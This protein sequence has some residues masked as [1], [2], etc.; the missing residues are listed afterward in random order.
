M[1]KGIM[2]L[3]AVLLAWGVAAGYLW[4]QWDRWLTEQN[5]RH[6]AW[7]GVRMTRDGLAIASV[8]LIRETSGGQ[9]RVQAQNLAVTLP[10]LAHGRL[11]FQ[12]LSAERLS[13]DWPSAEPSTDEEPMDWRA[14]GRI[15]DWL[16]ET[17][18]IDSFALTLPCPKGSCVLNGS[19]TLDQA[20]RDRFPLALL[21]ILQEQDLRAVINGVL[22][23]TA[24]GWQVQAHTELDG[25]R[26]LQLEARLHDAT[27][28]LSGSLQIPRLPDTAALFTWMNQW[29][30][31]TGP[32]PRTPTG[33]QINLTWQVEL[34]TA[35][36]ELFVERVRNGSG[37]LDVEGDFP[38]PWPV[39]GLGHVQGAL[40]MTWLGH[41]GQWRPTRLR[42]ALRL[43]ELA[44]LWPDDLPSEWAPAAVN[45][46]S[47]PVEGD[48]EA[49]LGIQLNLTMEGAISG[50]IHGRL[51]LLSMMPWHIGI[52]QGQI[53]IIGQRLSYQDW[54][55]Q[56][57]RLHAPF[58]AQMEAG[59]LGLTLESGASLEVEEL[60]NGD[61]HLPLQI[62]L[63]DAKLT[64]QATDEAFDVAFSSPIE[65]SS[66]AVRQALLKTQ[67]WS[68]KGAL[69]ASSQGLS[70]KGE[71]EN[72][73]ALKASVNARYPVSDGIQIDAK[74]QDVF[75]RQGNPLADTFAD[76]P[77]VLTFSNG[78]LQAGAELVMPLNEKPLSLIVDAQLKDVDGI[79][80]RMEL[81]KLNGPVKAQ[82]RNERL[83]VAF[84]ELTLHQANPGV[85]LGPIR[86]HGRY[87]AA[88][89]HL[90]QG[91]LDWETVEIG[92]FAGQ[93]RIAAGQ[94][95]F[96]A[97]RQRI[98]IDVSGLEIESILQAYPAEGLAGKG[99][100][101]GRLPLI[102]DRKGL[103]VENG[104]VKARDSGYLRFQ[105]EKIQAMG[106][107]N[108]AMQLVAE[109]LEDFHY[110]HLSSRV[111]YAADGTLTLAIVLQGRNPDVEKG[112]QI[113]L[114]V[115][116]QENLPNLF[117]SLQLSDRVNEQ[118]RERVEKKLREPQSK[119]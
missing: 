81:H 73:G 40:D 116:L 96:A 74:F 119:P 17:I 88:K 84:P 106:R 109:A 34:A 56:K 68:F 102:I 26:L 118:V 20:G 45:V 22:H 82:W 77:A 54:R 9:Q 112:R 64:T 43:T 69:D 14:I 76:W 12:R 71:V 105:S 51:T 89:D 18:Q 95:D 36:S 85:L 90:D 35:E 113:N 46:Q 117:T 3:S 21:L 78:R 37:R 24:D 94:L 59:R 28:T 50:N 39:P 61:V 57:A 1:R 100:V 13:I 5:I 110:N 10:D 2:V 107:S 8:E 33:M 58:T 92:L 44:G 91:R 93:A 7:D 111:D 83:S 99:T 27:N 25:E 86:L 32:M 97:A 11:R 38:D 62:A 19:L 104:E 52:E 66:R 70:L 63:A 49:P 75:F 29:L 98:D 42:S 16:P 47:T 30:S 55:A 101:D 114:N 23:E 108:P 67:R 15:V 31:A 41:A 6:V 79:Y 80:D 60:T 87:Q 4:W 65:L 72:A 103:T 115:N 53:D 48:S